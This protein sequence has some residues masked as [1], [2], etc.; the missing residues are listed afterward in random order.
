MGENNNNNMNQDQ[1]TSKVVKD[2]ANMAKKQIK[3]K[4]MSIASA[5]VSAISTLAIKIAL[6]LV[7]VL[8]ISGIIKWVQEKIESLTSPKVIYES[9][10]IEDTSELVEIKKDSDGD[11]Y[12]LEFVNNYEKNLEDAA[13]KLAQGYGSSYDTEMLKKF[14]KTEMSTTFPNLGGSGEGFQGIINVKRI[15]PNKEIGEMKSDAGNKQIDLKYVDKSTFDN[16][17][18][19]NDS[20]ALEVFTLSDDNKEIITAT[21]SYDGSTH[22]TTNSGMDYRSVTSQ[23]TMPFEYLLFFQITGNDEQFSTALADLALN[24]SID[25]VI[26]DNITTIETSVVTTTY[27]YDASGIETSNSV[28]SS[29][30]TVQE[31]VST[32]INLSEI[33]A[34]WVKRSCS[35]EN[36]SDTNV[37]N[38]IEETISQE[39]SKDGAS[40]STK[41]VTTST[42]LNNNVICTQN[43]KESK[44]Q[45]FV[46]IFKNSTARGN[47]QE[48]W[49]I[50][51]ISSNEKT[52][53]MVE[54]TKYLLYKATDTDYGV[55]KFEDIDLLS[56]VGQDGNLTYSNTSGIAGDEGII[57]DFFLRKGL[58]PNAVAAI[59]GNINAESGCRSNNSQD[60]FDHDDVQ[61]TNNVDNGTYSKEEFIND[62]VGYGLAQ[63]TYPT[64]KESL[65]E[66]AKNK[67][68][69]IGDLNMQLEFL[70]EEL[71][72]SHQDILQYLQE[73]GNDSIDSLTEYYMDKF[74]NPTTPRLA[75]R[76]QSANDYYNKYK[77]NQT[78]V[79]GSK[80]VQLGAEMM[81]YMIDNGYLYSQS[82]NCV[83]IENS[84]KKTGK[85]VDCSS[86]VCWVL[87]RAGYTDINRLNTNTLPPYLS[88]KGFKKITSLSDMKEGDIAFFPGHTQ[89]YAGTE[90]GKRKY[91]N[92]GHDPKTVYETSEP[93]GFLYAYRVP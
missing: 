54:L 39:I 33:D 67:Q 27:E 87:Y 12:H 43:N 92:A 58:T 51:F 35:F 71:N 10:E 29:E 13:I 9:L 22:I 23:Y 40:R 78:T 56:D 62:K 73:H 76:K 19:N 18:S 37:S 49:L 86:Y 61:Y 82:V 8:V 81:Q 75:E 60:T 79:N 1:Q 47:I 66:F 24:S 84:E 48:S 6:L 88:G 21:W 5:L 63:W 31:D 70:W 26:T 16:Y 25:I 7:V 3:S 38:P 20:K 2:I 59:M 57:F 15:T 36:T 44:H 17:V 4:I 83:P 32:S 65:Y 74:E 69:S 45:G 52:A 90:N 34:W 28:D 64:R 50:D 89:I 41:R 68:T 55:T 85:Y 91:L 72:T 80:I 93:S 77:N 14:M 46:D 30:T 53:N 11:G 42:T